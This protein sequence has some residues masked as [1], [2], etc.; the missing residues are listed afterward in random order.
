MQCIRVSDIQVKKAEYKAY[1]AMVESVK[2]KFDDEAKEENKIAL[3]SMMQRAKSGKL[4]MPPFMELANAMLLSI[5]LEMDKGGSWDEIA[6]SQKKYHEEI[7]NLEKEYDSKRKEIEGPNCGAYIS[8]ANDYMEK[9]SI[10]TIEYQ[11]TYLHIYK[12]FY[13]D[14]AYWSLFSSPDKHA[15]RAAFCGLTSSLLGVL[16]QLAETHFLDVT[17]DCSSNEEL[18]REAEPIEIKEKCPI[19][20]DGFEIPFGVGK[21]NFSCEKVE[22]QLG[23][24]LILNVSH[25]FTSGETS[26]AV[27]PG[28][29]IVGPSH[30]AMKHVPELPIGHLSFSLDVGAK[31]QIFLTFDR[32][33]QV[34]DYGSKF[35]AEFDVLGIAKEF[36]TGYTAGVNSG[37]ELDGPLKNIVDNI[38]DVPKEEPQINKNV[39]KYKEHE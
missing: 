10:Q 29:S 3:E 35:T 39:K 17:I 11:K 12:D 27:G 15:Q 6:R 7:Q 37:I 33:G 38:L 5:D 30:E 24:V 31:Q 13:H 9:M 16:L 26:I 21:F 18:N 14:M 32:N 23:E 34:M 20:E 8:L 4:R 19:G 36:S 28:I 2:K 22:L 1:R 25:K